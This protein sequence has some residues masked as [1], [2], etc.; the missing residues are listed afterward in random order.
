MGG[1]LLTAANFV[2]MRKLRGI[3]FSVL[4]FA[5]SVM[6]AGVNF[7]NVKR[8]YFLYE[9]HFGSFFSSYMY[10]VKAAET[11]R[12]YEKFVRLTLMKLT[13][14]S[15]V[16]LLLQISPQLVYAIVVNTSLSETWQ[17]NL[18]SS[19]IVHNSRT[20]PGPNII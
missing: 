13:P 1:T 7:I 11:R 12:S 8:T 19:W 20:F 6:S 9:W 16:K 10:I 14:G 2:C 18:I 17:I 5:F 15:L 4:I 3:H